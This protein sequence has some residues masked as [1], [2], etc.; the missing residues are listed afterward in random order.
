MD[1]NQNKKKAVRYPKATATAETSKKKHHKEIYKNEIGNILEKLEEQQIHS[2]SRTQFDLSGA[3]PYLFD[4]LSYIC[5][6]RKD[7]VELADDPQSTHFRVTISYNELLD[8]A[9]DT[10]KEQ[11]LLLLQN[12]INLAKNPQGK[13]I[14]ISPTKSITTIPIIVSLFRE[15]DTK[16]PPNEIKRLENLKNIENEIPIKGVQILFFK[17][18]FYRLFENTEYGADWFPMPKA[19]QAKLVY[20]LKTQQN[21]PQLLRYKVKGY[22]VTYR[23]YFLY[24]NLHDNSIGEKLT[25]NSI[26][27]WE[28]INPREVECKN[29]KKYLKRWGKARTFLQKANTVLNIM[30][31]KGLLDGAKTAPKG[32]WYEPPLKEYTVYLARKDFTELSELKDYSPNK[33][34]PHYEEKK[35][36]T[37]EE[38]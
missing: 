24:L 38:L 15:L 28:R 2:L 9:L 30:A 8:F 5:T 17:G 16:L 10:H 1:Q 11:K 25:L 3:Y 34:L 6:H 36:S 29:G 13:T 33:D 12:L 32:V 7:L 35:A 22:P 37:P 27:L 14:P 19:F 31:H 21:N 18:L 4:A 23:R 20:T 26:D